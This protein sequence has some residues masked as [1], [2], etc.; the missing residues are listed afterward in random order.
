MSETM[1][2]IL[3]ALGVALLVVVLVPGLL[4][5]G[6][7]AS[8]MGGGMMDGWGAWVTGSLIL[9]VLVAGVAFVVIGV[10]KRR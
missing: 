4:M 5:T 3:I 1:R 10:S 8:M 6:M 2:T 9:L 7:M